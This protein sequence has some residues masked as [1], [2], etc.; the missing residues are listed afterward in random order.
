MCPYAIFTYRNPTPLFTFH[1]LSTIIPKIYTYSCNFEKK[2]IFYIFLFLIKL[3]SSSFYINCTN[4]YTCPISSFSL[5]CAKKIVCI[6]RISNDIS[7][8]IIVC[9]IYRFVTSAVSILIKN[10]SCNLSNIFCIR[11]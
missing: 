4:S 5:S 7:N 3:R 10:S 6:C 8:T 2:S 1:F 9:K 11:G